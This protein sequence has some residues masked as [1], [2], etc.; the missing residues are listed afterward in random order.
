M[1]GMISR[2]QWHK[3]TSMITMTREDNIDDNDDDD[4]II[5]RI[6]MTGED[7]INDNDDNIEDNDE[8]SPRQEKVLIRQKC[9]LSAA[10][11]QPSL[12]GQR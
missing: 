10:V 3:M 5:S 6:T 9:L 12:Q 7:T 2:V 8:E 4:K 11:H 1:T